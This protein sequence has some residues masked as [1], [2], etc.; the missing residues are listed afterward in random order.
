MSTKPRKVVKCSKA[1]LVEAALALS[2]DE[3]EQ[4][5]AQLRRLRLQPSDA[6]DL[7]A[8]SQLF[9][10]RLC[11][12]AVLH[13]QRTDA[14]LQLRWLALCARRLRAPV[15]SRDCLREIFRHLTAQDLF[16]FGGLEWNAEL[17]TSPDRDPT[18]THFRSTREALRL[19]LGENSFEELAPLPEPRVGAC[20]V[21][22]GDEVL[23]MGGYSDK[24]AARFRATMA[25]LRMW[26]QRALRYSLQSGSWDTYTEPL[27]QA[28]GP[29]CSGVVYRDTLFVCGNADAAIDL[30]GRREPF[31]LPERPRLS[32]GRRRPVFHAQVVLVGSYL[33]C[34]AVSGC[35]DAGS[36][37][38]YCCNQLAALDLDAVL[39]GRDS[40]QWQLLPTPRPHLKDDARLLLRG[41]MLT[42]VGGTV[43]LASG[44]CEHCDSFVH[45]GVHRTLD[46]ARFPLAWQEPHEDPLTWSGDRVD[47][48]ACLDMLAFETFG[49]GVLALGGCDVHNQCPPDV[50]L[51]S[52]MR[53]AVFPGGVGRTHA[54]AVLV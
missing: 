29:H 7:S 30:L 52:N 12:A 13:A 6:V 31:A 39:D 33:L 17:N 18:L 28:A 44:C 21:V 19:R 32:F 46:L 8:A 36:S 43:M 1:Q 48:D 2:P 23:V 51:G 11:K 40:P 20:A 47:A 25:G 5:A 3:E 10:S 54:A 26:P 38:S 42:L 53:A 50:M 16:V 14:R 9:T 41:T 15:L 34:W 35:T 24:R 45:T 49:R 37:S 4:Q 22:Y 27:L